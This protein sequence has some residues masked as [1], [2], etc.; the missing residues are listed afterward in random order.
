MANTA[1]V[2]DTTLTPLTT[3]TTSK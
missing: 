1:T 3:T 2:D